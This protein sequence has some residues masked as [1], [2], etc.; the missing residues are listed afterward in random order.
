VRARTLSSGWLWVAVAATLG[1]FASASVLA[2]VSWVRV[3]ETTTR[4]IELSA[5]EGEVRRLDEVLTMSAWMYASTGL[6]EWKRRYEHH[7]APLDAAIAKTKA[8]S[9]H[10]LGQSIGES[11]EAANHALIALESKSMALVDAGAREQAASVL[12][13]EGYRAEKKRYSAGMDNL[14]STLRAGLQAQGDSI[15]DLIRVLCVAAVGSLV[16][17]ACSWWR[18]L[19]WIRLSESAVQ[20]EEAHANAVAGRVAHDADAGATFRVRAAYALVLVVLGVMLLARHEYFARQIARQGDAAADINV[21]GRQRTLS[22]VISRQLASLAGESEARVRS[23]TGELLARSAEEWDCAAGHLKKVLP[24][25]DALSGGVYAA[26]ME[27]EAVRQRLAAVIAA[28]V[29]DARDGGDALSFTA[30]AVAFT[31]H[32]REFLRAADSTAFAMSNELRLN[33]QSIVNQMYWSTGIML[34]ALTVIGVAIM[35]PTLSR[36]ARAERARRLLT[37]EL[38]RAKQA[39][40]D[41]AQAKSIFLANISHEI[42]TP[43]NG[44]IGFAELLS[45]GPEHT[46][47][48]QRAEWVGIINA[49][50]RHLLSLVND[51]LDYSK[52]DAG[53]MELEPAP[54]RPADV[55][56]ECVALVKERAV[57]RS[58]SVTVEI[59]P[60]CPPAVRVDATRLRQ[61]VTNLVS[62]A[63]KFTHHGGVLVSVSHDQTDTPRLRV[64]VK[65]SGIGIAPDQLSRLFEPFVQAD[66]STTR[67][68]GGTGLGLS[69]SRQ[70]ARRMGGDISVQSAPGLGSVFTV[71]VDA[72]ALSGPVTLDVTT[73]ETDPISPGVLSGLRVL[74]TDDNAVNQRLFATVIRR[75]GAHVVQASNGKEAVD[76]VSAGPFDLI[77]MDMQMP[78]MDGRAATIAIRSYGV[79]TPIVAL[80][81]HSSN[82]HRDQCL[83]A[84]CTDYLSKPVD[85]AVLVGTIARLTGRSAGTSPPVARDNEQDESIRAIGLDWLSTLPGRVDE[86]RTAIDAG[87]LD[88]A[89]AIAHAL[90]G[91][92][93]TLGFPEFVAPA[94]ELERTGVEGREAEARVAFDRLARLVESTLAR[95][96]PAARVA[97][98]EPG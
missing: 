38:L 95:T 45:R 57:E 73:T 47:P 76:A 92:S 30:H 79:T 50:G 24:T 26:F 25:N 21:A 67:R 12:A 93:G 56:G 46:D 48:A 81:A 32:E 5:A 64:S 19:R 60:A 36:F 94:G 4:S 17:A 28:A 70:I 54:C 49:S 27:S 83:A 15:R 51:V 80:T 78:V 89:A 65:D 62:N 44:I 39:T 59:D 68:Y 91:T 61:I 55:V 29:Q 72:P 7:V 82:A 88:T 6:P 2:W 75:S 3:A 96:A 52:L 74:I 66:Q 16:L 98:A 23:A 34:L 63:V 41:A 14:W 13:S 85:L 58:V 31:A 77:L 42:R 53:K 43:L 87:R 20:R 40:E 69:I 18:A 8:L 35:E 33:A 90:K 22:Q 11:T 10:V 9:E 37:E 71:E 97:H 84:G 1:V 86:L